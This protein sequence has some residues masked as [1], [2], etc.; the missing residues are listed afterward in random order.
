LFKS[1]FDM[2]LLRS[3]DE[4]LST[5]GDELSQAV[6]FNLER[7][8]IRKKEIPN[9]IEVFTKTIEKIMG[10]GAVGLEVCI[11]K[12]LY[13]KI[14]MVFEQRE[15][16]KLELG[17]YVRKARQRVYTDFVNS[18]QNSLA[19][20]HLENVEDLDSFTLVAINTNASKLMAVNKDKATGGSISQISHGLFPVQTPRILAEVITSGR[21]KAVGTFHCED[22]N[23]CERCFTVTAFPVS[24]NCVG[25]AFKDVVEHARNSQRR[26]TAEEPRSAVVSSSHWICSERDFDGPHSDSIR[27]Q[28]VQAQDGPRPVSKA[29]EA[30][31]V[32][33][34][35]ELC[36]SITV[37]ANIDNEN[38]VKFHEAIIQPLADAKAKLRIYVEV[39]GTSDQGILESV[40]HTMKR[41]LLQNNI[42]AQ[43]ETTKRTG[44]R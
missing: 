25:L 18:M 27:F 19:V 17:E 15:S 6:Y 11:A 1:D 2:L 22:E 37:S 35:P 34:E 28:A 21:A 4:V 31:S 44:K 38:W 24:N 39:S 8:N 5:V 42:T 12:Q 14:G 3:V 43:V 29:V 16:T 40:G 20:F 33:S 41:S 32:P 36:E 13:D 26:A 23:R 30:R 9:K 7:L 10:S